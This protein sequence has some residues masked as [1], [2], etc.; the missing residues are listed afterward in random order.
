MGLGFKN[1]MKESTTFVT[2]LGWVI[3]PGLILLFEI[4]FK[5]ISET[6]FILK[7]LIVWICF[8]PDEIAVTFFKSFFNFFLSISNSA[9][10]AKQFGKFFM[11]GRI[12]FNCFLQCL[13]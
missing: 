1:N 5:Q 12:H 13:P 4:L 10:E 8:E 9:L 3:F 6:F 11:F 2:A 7:C